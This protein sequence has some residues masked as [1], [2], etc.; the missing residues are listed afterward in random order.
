MQEFDDDHLDGILDEDDEVLTR[1]REAQILGQVWIDEPPAV[2]PPVDPRQ[3]KEWIEAMGVGERLDDSCTALAPWGRDLV[4]RL[5]D[6]R[7][8]DVLKPSKLVSSR[9]LSQDARRRLDHLVRGYLYYHALRAAVERRRSETWS[10]PIEPYAL[11]GL[12]QDRAGARPSCWTARSGDRLWLWPRRPWDS[13]GS[14]R[15]GD[16]RRHRECGW[17][18]DRGAQVA[19]RSRTG[20]E[21]HPQRRNGSELWPRSRSIPLVRGGTSGLGRPRAV[22]CGMDGR[23]R[24]SA[25]DRRIP[26]PGKHGTHLAG[27]RGEDQERQVFEGVENLRELTSQGCPCV[28][29][30]Q[31]TASGREGAG[32]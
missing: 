14:K 7:V 21:A 18:N 32:S 1:S 20:D 23:L 22:S 27:G 13:I 19:A 26:R 16:S 9:R 30:L 31:S 5:G 4:G 29:S 12:G 11:Q 15:P 24:A 17:T 3:L 6:A 10:R 2:R 8:R 25:T 28:S